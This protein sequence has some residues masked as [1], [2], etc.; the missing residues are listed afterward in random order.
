MSVST[1]S[2]VNFPVQ[3]KANWR[4]EQLVN[5]PEL[6]QDWLLDPCSLT[7]RLK[8][9]C[10]EFRVEVIGQN[11]EPCA[12]YEATGG[13]KTGQEVLIREVLLFCDDVPHVFARSILPLSSLTG[14]EKKLASLGNQSLGQV[15][16]NHPN[17]Q[18][19]QIELATFDQAS[20]A[21]KL[22]QHYN[23][24]CR[25]DLWGRRSVFMLDNKPLIVAEVFLP[26]AIAYHK[27]RVC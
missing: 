8:K 3:M 17:L 7:A 19:N 10:G 11:I 14:N 4:N 6:L 23:Q 16:F 21:A 22:A 12:H 5:L 24:E 25:E 27:E 9:H 20:S 15:I 13:V 18:R 2:S 1:T 26:E